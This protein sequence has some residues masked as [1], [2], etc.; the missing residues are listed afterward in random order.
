MAAEHVST[1][2]A[3]QA[4]LDRLPRLTL[5]RPLSSSRTRQPRPAALTGLHSAST[6]PDSSTIAG[7]HLHPRLR[8]LPA[9]TGGSP[10]PPFVSTGGHD[11]T[12]FQSVLQPHIHD[13][14]RCTLFVNGCADF[15]WKPVLY[16][17]TCCLQQLAKLLNLWMFGCKREC[18]SKNRPRPSPFA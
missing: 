13:H 8:L 14:T 7:L 11:R 3:L 12:S 4:R 6:S 16:L 9:L 15:P 2:P 10:A 1:Q 5:S 18:R 17:L